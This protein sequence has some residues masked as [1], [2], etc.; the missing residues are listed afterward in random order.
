MFIIRG[1]FC[2]LMNVSETFLVNWRTNKE[3][4]FIG[5]YLIN[6]ISFMELIYTILIFARGFHCFFPGKWY[7]IWVRIWATLCVP[8][9]RTVQFC[10]VVG[11]ILKARKS[12]KKTKDER[13]ENLIFAFPILVI[14]INWCMWVLHKD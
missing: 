8:L 3:S 13:N 12:N 4:G 5:R 9:T 7:E 2:I 10:M 11:Y 1:R 14:Y 6:N